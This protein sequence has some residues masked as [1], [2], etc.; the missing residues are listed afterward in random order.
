MYLLSNQERRDIIRLLGVLKDT[1]PV[2]KSLRRENMV[3][4][5]GLL[6]H[7]LEKK[8]PIHNNIIKQLKDAIKE[9]H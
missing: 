8:Q 4:V 6:I 2:G 5:A 1:L 3:R 7:Q 9:C